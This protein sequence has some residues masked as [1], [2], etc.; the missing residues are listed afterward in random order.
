MT[1][2]LC[3]LIHLPPIQPY[4][5]KMRALNIS[6]RRANPWEQSSLRNFI[7]QHFS[8]GWADEVS[9]AFASKP[10]TCFVAIHDKKIVGFSAYE[11]T[12]RNY[13]GPTGVSPKYE[14]RGI[15]TA[16]LHASLRG[17]QSLGYSYAVIGYVSSLEYYQKAAN[18][19][20]IPFDEGKGIY[21]LKEEPAFINES[22]K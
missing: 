5:L 6:I 2:M 19:I 22:T 4:L 7:E 15:G 18:A 17:L 13:F 1:D 11:C 10:V 20:V 16:L 8:V 12:R 3:S 21:G 9:V 14:K